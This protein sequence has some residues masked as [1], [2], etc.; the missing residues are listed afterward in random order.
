MKKTSP[1]K[2]GKVVAERRYIVFAGFQKLRGGEV[3]WM[4][5]G[6]GIYYFPLSLCKRNLEAPVLAPES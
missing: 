3:I 2:V 4:C 6:E 1:H 5:A